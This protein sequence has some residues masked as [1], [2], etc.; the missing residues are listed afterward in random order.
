[1]SPFIEGLVISTL[2]ETSNE[3]TKDHF[4][5]DVNFF[6]IYFPLSL[7]CNIDDFAT[8]LPY[9]LLSTY[10]TPNRVHSEPWI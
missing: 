9:F 7:C 10:L 5:N 8:I 2:L 6:C 1:M 4:F 3:K